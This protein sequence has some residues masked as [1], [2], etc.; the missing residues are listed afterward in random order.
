MFLE[1]CKCTVYVLVIEI[2]INL[3][4]VVPVIKSYLKIR[5]KITIS[6]RS[7]FK[8]LYVIKVILCYIHFVSSITKEE[9]K[10]FGLVLFSI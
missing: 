4:A 1:H 6:C 3:F 5:L 8:H 10:N 9:I 2:F 7:S